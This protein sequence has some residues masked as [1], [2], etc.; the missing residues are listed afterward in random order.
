M[1]S[2]ISLIIG[3]VLGRKE[4]YASLKTIFIVSS[5]FVV[6]FFVSVLVY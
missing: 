4:F 6:F 3:I 1:P 2:S 5:L